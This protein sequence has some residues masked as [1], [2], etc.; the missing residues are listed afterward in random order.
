MKDIIYMDL[1]K[2]HL[3]KS[4]LTKRDIVSLEKSNTII[5]ISMDILVIIK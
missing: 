5:K 3:I 2:Y 4:L 1:L